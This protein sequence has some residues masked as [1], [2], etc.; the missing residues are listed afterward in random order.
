[1]NSKLSFFKCNLLCRLASDSGGNI[2]TIF[3][4]SLVPMML[5]TGAGIDY[6]RAARA[7]TK[8][9]AIADATALMTLTQY[10]FNTQA[11]DSATSLDTTCPVV[12]S[13]NKSSLA[14]ADAQKMFLGQAASVKD[15]TI[16]TPTIQICDKLTT[17]GGTVSKSRTTK[18]NYTATSTN[19]FGSFFGVPSLPVNNN[20]NGAT[21]TSSIAPNIDIYVL[22]DSSPSMQ[23]PDSAAGLVQLKKLTNGCGFACHE[24]S[25]TGFANGMTA[26]TKVN[27]STGISTLN[28]LIRFSGYG[29]VCSTQSYVQSRPNTSSS[30]WTNVSGPPSMDCSWV[31]NASNTDQSGTNAFG[32]QAYMPYWYTDTGGNIIDS[33]TM[34][35]NN[36]INLRINDAK[37]A[38]ASLTSTAA[39]YNTT[40][41][42]NGTQIR[43]AIL[44]FDYQVYVQQTLTNN[45]TLAGVAAGNVNPLKV[46]T[47][48]YVTQGVLNTAQ[49]TQFET[50]MDSLATGGAN[51]IPAPGTG[52]GTSTPQK[53]VF[54]ITDGMDNTASRFGAID[55]TRCTTLKNAGINIG[56]IYIQSDAS[57]YQDIN[58]VA[59]PNLHVPQAITADTVSSGSS[60]VS[61]ALKS[62]A[63]SSTFYFSV[64]PG[65]NITAS[66]TALFSAV[67]S[68]SKL[69]Q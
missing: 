5:A 56:V 65:Q 68:G 48:S 31:A 60:P 16:T 64:G 52:Y 45:M 26:I 3:A 7:K 57:A 10:E 1:M 37:N 41:A 53:W 51:A 67:T 17:V 29:S 47:G 13:Q 38:V 23:I 34:A 59:N 44:N 49:D 20:N 42:A 22:M 18:V 28:S 35:V 4:F 8:L 32:G 63:S 39:N 2:M 54:I 46:Y 66:L 21:A 14:I 25:D 36:G 24:S 43:M 50:A 15:V 33:Y 58:G 62:C 61:S 69:I 40:N 27:N 11:E 55:T 6:S 30:T 19:M 9:D 12:G